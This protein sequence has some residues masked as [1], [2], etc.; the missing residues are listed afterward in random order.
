M[1]RSHTIRMIWLPPGFVLV[2]CDR[3]Q[4]EASQSR[5][6]GVFW[7]P[8]STCSVRYMVDMFQLD[9][10]TWLHFVNA[11]SWICT[12]NTGRVGCRQEA[13]LSCNL[14]LKVCCAQICAPNPSLTWML[15]RIIHN[16][17]RRVWLWDI[18]LFLK[19]DKLVKSIK[20]MHFL[21]AASKVFP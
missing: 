21:Q 8:W 16:A 17:C 9:S 13:S 4:W 15:V 2:L 3:A 11:E 7:S 12:T 10:F 20:K 1:Y 14:Q 6:D 5:N 18:I 19:S